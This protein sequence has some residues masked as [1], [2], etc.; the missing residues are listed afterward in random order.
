M[1]QYTRWSFWKIIPH[2]GCQ[3]ILIKVQTVRISSK[4]FYRK[5]THIVSKGTK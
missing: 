2:Q 5:F 1:N 3:I 4:I